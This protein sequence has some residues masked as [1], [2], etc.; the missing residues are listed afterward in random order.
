MQANMGR[1][2]AR[3]ETTKPALPPRTLL[4][5]LE[6]IGV[7]TAAT[8][9]LTGY[10]ARVAEAH[11]VQ[12]G[13]LVARVIGP[14][15]THRGRVLSVG[16]N[17]WTHYSRAINGTEQVACTLVD[18]MEAVTGRGELRFLTM[19]TWGAVVP[20]MGLLRRDRAWC[21]VCYQMWRD[22]DQPIYEPLL[23]SLRVV[24]VC[25]QH[26]Q[27]LCTRCPYAD[28]QATQNPLASRTR[29]GHC[30]RCQRWLGQSAM[31]PASTAEL[32]SLSS[33]NVWVI[34]ATGAMIAAAP[35]LRTVPTR[36]QVA[37]A[38][39]LYTPPSSEGGW[40]AVAR[41]AS[42]TKSHLYYWRHGEKLP[43]LSRLLQ[44][45][46][47]VGVTPVQFL[48]SSSGGHEEPR[49]KMLCMERQEKGTW[50][51][52]KESDP[53]EIQRCLEG[54]LSHPE[55]P[56][57]SL[58]QAAGVVGQ[59]EMTVRRL[60]PQLCYAI[61]ARHRAYRH[62]QRLQREAGICAAV[63]QAV[64]HLHAQGLYPSTHRVGQLLP[65]PGYLRGAQAAQVWRDTMQELGLRSPAP[66]AK[67][68][69]CPN[70]QD[71]L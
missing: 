34:E 16:Q 31:P 48:T 43:T 13:T 2:Y 14:L 62:R 53:Q 69:R 35:T 39:A 23:W 55:E 3:W 45:C 12:V 58:R 24:T 67:A 56:P 64:L 60:C 63:R 18:V 32:T 17:N 7:G 41:A 28:C 52:R 36:S 57:P 70:G 9:S 25:P 40:A 71:M 49:Q 42:L 33:W 26:N 68:C 66:T 20:A 30:A 44:L 11:C 59:T 19:L 22:R 8:E 61:V 29:P 21:P 6:P 15:F 1:A 4:Y 51:R 5:H 65:R 46:G 38:I 47:S 37:Q 50:R 27:T 10:I 54:L